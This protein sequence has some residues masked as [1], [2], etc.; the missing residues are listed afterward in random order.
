M[1]RNGKEVLDEKGL[2][3]KVVED[4]AMAT[5]ERDTIKTGES[6]YRGRRW[7]LWRWEMV[8]MEMGDGCYGDLVTVAMVT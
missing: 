8:A 4:V 1:I 7:L 6:Y 5:G 2:E 3:E